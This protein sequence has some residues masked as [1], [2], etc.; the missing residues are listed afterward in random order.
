MS[1]EIHRIRRNGKLEYRCYNNTIEAYFVNRPEFPFDNLEAC[2][3]HLASAEAEGNTPGWSKEERIAYWKEYL[4]KHS[5]INP[6]LPP[7]WGAVPLYDLDSFIELVDKLFKGEEE[8]DEAG[9]HSLGNSE[10]S[11]QC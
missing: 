2:I 8:A 11:D 7:H 6:D 4:A 10:I 9:G 5:C 3:E 1:N